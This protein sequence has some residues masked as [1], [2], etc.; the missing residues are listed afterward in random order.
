[1]KGERSVARAAW[2]QEVAR[3]RLSAEILTDSSGMGLPA[4]GWSGEVTAVLARESVTKEAREREAWRARNCSTAG[5]GLSSF[6]VD[7]TSAYMLKHLIKPS[8]A[9]ASCKA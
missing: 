6:A 1:M 4:G 9:E 2:T 7:V 3:R 8:A 5:W